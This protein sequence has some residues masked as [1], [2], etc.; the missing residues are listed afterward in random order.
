MPPLPSCAQALETDTNGAIICG[1]DETAAAG[2][3]DWGTFITYSTGKNLTSSTTYDVLVQG[4]LNVDG[5]GTST[6]QGNLAVMNILAVGGSSSSTIRG[7]TAT[8]TLGG[9][10]ANHLAV[11]KAITQSGGGTSTFVGGIYANALRF[12]QPSCNTASK[13]ITDSDGSLV[14]ALEAL[15]GAYTGTYDGNNFGGGVIDTGELIYGGSSGSFS[16]LGA[17]TR[18]TI[19]SMTT[20]GIPGWVSTSTFAHL[21]ANNIYTGS[22]TATLRNNEEFYGRIDVGGTATTT[23]RG[24]ATSSFSGG[25]NVLTGGITLSLP[26]CTAEL[27]TDFEGAIVCGTSTGGSANLIFSTLGTTKYYT[28]SS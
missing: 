13:L 20:G 24:N 12:N 14:C 17:G 26:S 22:D 6:I 15:D 16:E 4:E 5:A 3:S 10:S 21:N 9:L 7:S 18:G 11:T 27:E 23:I 8:S 2:T 19:L 28:A 1:V 25:I